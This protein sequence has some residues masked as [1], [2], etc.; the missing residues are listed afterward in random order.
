MY[1]IEFYA[2]MIFS[3]IQQLEKLS[4]TKLVLLILIA[5]VSRAIVY[6][7]RLVTVLICCFV[8]F[9]QNQFYFSTQSVVRK[10]IITFFGTI[11]L[12]YF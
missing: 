2:R 6:S 1:I 3:V 12:V 5:F 10:S 11:V 8:E 7:L 9:T 4:E